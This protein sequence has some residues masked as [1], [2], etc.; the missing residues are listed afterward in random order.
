MRFEGDKLL[1]GLAITLAEFKNFLISEINRGT[2]DNEKT[3]KL[4][5]NIMTIL[6]AKK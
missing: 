6:A 3:R 1:R 4:L 2:K 5:V